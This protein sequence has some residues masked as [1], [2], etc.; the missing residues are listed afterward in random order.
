MMSVEKMSSNGM[1]T[2]LLAAGNSSRLGRPKQLLV[3]GGQTLLQYSLQIALSSKAHPAV[4]VLG[5]H[6]DLIE[7]EM[8]NKGV[9]I[10]VNAEWQEG[11]ASSI[12]CGIKFLSELTPSVEGA[13]LMVCDQPYVTTSLLNDLITAH[14]NTGKA[15]VACSY[16]NTFGPPTLFHKKLFPE[17]LQ[18]RGDVGARSVIQRHANEVEVVSFPAGNIDVDT[19]ADFQGLSKDNPEH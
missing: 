6:A 18:L 13:I 14:Q 1:G 7:K 11:M 16:A 12:R 15:I 19:E 10:V 2:I 4:V 5:A 3:N 9:Y 17:L 8:D